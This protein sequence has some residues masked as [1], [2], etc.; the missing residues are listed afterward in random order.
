M[1][2]IFSFTRASWICG[3]LVF[4]PPA[5]VTQRGE[6]PGRLL[7][8]LL[9]IYFW[10]LEA[11]F[12]KRR[13]G[14]L[15][16]PSFVYPPDAHCRPFSILSYHRPTYRLQTCA[17]VSAGFVIRLR[18]LSFFFNK[19]PSLC[20]LFLFSRQRKKSELGRQTAPILPCFFSIIVFFFLVLL[21]LCL[22]LPYK[23]TPVS[24][25]H[26]TQTNSSPVLNERLLSP[27]PSFPFYF[28]SWLCSPLA[29]APVAFVVL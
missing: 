27:R 7:L 17:P 8:F 16:M 29:F 15:T 13:E 14:V 20:F 26:A 5:R 23:C 24:G 3:S 28:F 10:L 2:R 6:E 22:R 19:S 25:E 11:R 4:Y 12:F 18:H 21:L 1:S 9:S